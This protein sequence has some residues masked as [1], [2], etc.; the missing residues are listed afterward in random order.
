MDII[1]ESMIIIIRDEK[2]TNIKGAEANTIYY[3]LYLAL[4]SD[5]AAL[6]LVLTTIISNT[7]SIPV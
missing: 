2:A 4:H 3:G 7:A 1:W 5:Y 6:F